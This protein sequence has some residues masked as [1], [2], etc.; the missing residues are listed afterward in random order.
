MPAEP[1]APTSALTPA[2][3]R[4]SASNIAI[5]PAGQ[6]TCLPTEA[7]KS[8]AST[9][10]EGNGIVDLLAERPGERVAIEIETGKSDIPANLAKL[11]DAGFSRV[12]LLATSPSAV[13]ACQRAIAQATTVHEASV[14]QL[15]WL[16]VS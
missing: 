13:T 5:G 8:R 9:L 4:A 10:S 15:T 3:R 14:E 7:S 16:D 2:P 6:P 1:F 11:R 12:I